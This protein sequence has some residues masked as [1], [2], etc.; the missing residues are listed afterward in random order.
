MVFEGHQT[1]PN[2]SVELT[3]AAYLIII[4][5]Y[6]QQAWQGSWWEGGRFCGEEDQSENFV[7]IP[8]ALMMRNCRR[9]RAW[10]LATTVC[11][12]L[13]G[14]AAGRQGGSGL[15]VTGL[16][17]RAVQCGGSLLR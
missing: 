6:P 16:L 9:H 2:F 11:G 7:H 10:P 12:G 15:V 17:V 8:P 5:P 14:K 13:V 1:Q 4:L 3:A